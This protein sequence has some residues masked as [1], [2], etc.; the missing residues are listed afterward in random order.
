MT[1]GA[2]R[3]AGMLAG[4][5]ALTGAAVA[6]EGLVVSVPSPLTAEAVARIKGRLQAAKERPDRRPDVV[7][8]DFNPLDK[9]AASADYGTCGDLAEFIATQHDLSTV[10][11]VHAKTTGHLALPV[12]ACKQLV[13]GPQ[14]ALG[15][16]VAAGDAPLTGYKANAYLEIVGKVRPS[17]LAVA[18]KLFDKDVSLRKGKKA[19]ADW[20]VDARDRPKFADQGVELTDNAQLSD[21]PDGRVGMLNLRALKDTG[22]SNQTVD[23]KPALLDALGLA[24]TALRDDPLGGRAALPFRLTVSGKVDTGLRESVARQVREIVKQQGNQI[25]LFLECG[26]GDLAAARELADELRQIQNPTGGEEAVQVI[27]V[28]LDRAPDTAA[29]IALGCSEIVLSKRMDVP[30][31]GEAVF[32]DFEAI[33]KQPG[34]NPQFLAAS[35]KEL[36]ESQ[37]YPPLLA[38]GMVNRDLEIVRAH[39]KAN[40][41][42]RRLMTRADYEAEKDKLVLDVEVKPKGQYFKL[43]ATQAVDLGL[44]R[45]LVDTRDPDAVFAKFGTDPAKVRSATPAWLDRF[46]NY[47]R[48]PAITFLLVVVGFTG[49]LLELKVPG[50]TVPGIVAALCFGLVFWAHAFSGQVAVLAGFLFLLG[51]VLVLIEVFLLPGFGAAGVTGIVCMLGALA[52]LTVGG[53]NGLPST[54]D[55]WLTIGGRA[56]QYLLAMVGSVVVA[57]T[58][59]RFLPSIPYANRLVLP[60]PADRATDSEPD[61]PGVAAAAALLGA[62]GTSVTILRPAGTVQFGDGYVDV[63]TEG[64]FIPAG[65][66]VQVVEVEGTRIVVKEV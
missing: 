29:V 47:L 32:G 57:F 37:G 52:I 55:G 7:V 2:C 60:P 65:A 6:A 35:L 58:L 56:A 3:I 33:L 41:S 24:P 51:V 45:T 9:D 20:Y 48:L 61:L 16:V 19:G 22:L 25:F 40:R 42:A 18:R 15:E 49:L 36:A 62:V 53:A 54:T 34:Q 44:A 64:G 12:L 66:R 26:G 50:V 1:A 31:G 59:A 63:V 17:H 8:F 4:L 5:L 43:T 28:V 10:A 23:G 11:Y 46:G 38:E 14:A 39:P 27:A 30:N 13:C 21:V